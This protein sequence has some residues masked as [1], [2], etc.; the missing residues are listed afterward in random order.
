MSQLA[1][2]CGR[3]GGGVPTHL[4]SNWLSVVSLGSLL[5]RRGAMCYLDMQGTGKD[6]YSRSPSRGA[7][8]LETPSPSATCPLG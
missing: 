7:E 2:V 8:R 3:G 5:G 4:G 6:L 1:A